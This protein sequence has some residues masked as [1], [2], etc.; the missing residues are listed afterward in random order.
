[1]CTHVCM[2]LNALWSSS[3]GHVLVNIEDIGDAAPHHR[4]LPL[5]RVD[6]GHRPLFIGICIQQKLQLDSS[7]HDAQRGNSSH[8]LGTG[9][10]S[11]VAGHR[12]LAAKPRGLDASKIPAGASRHSHR[13]RERRT[14][15]WARGGG[16][17]AQA[18]SRSCGAPPP[19]TPPS[20][21]PRGAGSVAAP[22]PAGT[23]MTMIGRKVRVQ[24]ADRA[25]ASH[26]TRVFGEGGPPRASI[27]RPPTG[28]RV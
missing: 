12:G 13:G 7:A 21:S 4:L 1:M 26:A 22:P 10:A 14:R 17:G 19:Q 25:L 18:P 8:A 24:V 16:A 6:G 28:L 11:E 2:A 3:A 20:P 27:K 15:R 5:R 9:M 23:G